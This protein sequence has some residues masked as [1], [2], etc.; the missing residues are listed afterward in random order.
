MKLPTLRNK[1]LE[2]VL[3]IAR[4]S[5]IPLTTCPTCMAEPIDVEPGVEGW[6]NGTYKFRGKTYDCDCETQMALRKHYLLANIGDQYQ[7]LD[8]KDYTGSEEVKSRVAIYLE[9]WD[10]A[11]VNGM[12]MEFASPQ[13]G[14]GKTFAATYVGKQLIKRGENVFFI[15]FL[16]VIS[17]LTN[18]HRHQEE[19]EARLYETT[20]LILD[21]VV[22]P[23]TAPQANLFSG[24]LEELIRNRTNANLVNIMTTNMTQDELHDTYPRVYSLLSAK[25]IRVVMEGQDARQNHIAQENLELLLNDEVRP[26]T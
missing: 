10:K 20:V 12:G 23:W 6:E 19:Y 11:R 18:Q 2:Q 26:I 14:V 9:K 8:W 15:P 16:E 25:Q 3:E 4:K 5:G 22:P 24:K 1:D 13:L 7:R 17:V 21:E